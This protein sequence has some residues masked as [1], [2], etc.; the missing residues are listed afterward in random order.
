MSKDMRTLLN[1]VTKIINEGIEMSDNG[2]INIPNEPKSITELL[3]FLNDNR[4]E[5]LGWFDDVNIADS[6]F[7]MNGD[8]GQHESVEIMASNDQYGYVFTIYKEDLA[9][10]FPGKFFDIDVNGVTIWACPFKYSSMRDKNYRNSDPLTDD[11]YD[12]FNVI[13]V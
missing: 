13:R 1:K 2:Q 9:D 8:I 10:E 3:I 4:D 5:V 7:R 11:G 6:D 12:E